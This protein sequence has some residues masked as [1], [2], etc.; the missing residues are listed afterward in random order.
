MTR[1]MKIFE[2]VFRIPRRDTEIRFVTKFNKNRPLPKGR[3]V[4]ETIKLGLR[5]T[6]PSPHFGRSR[7]KFPERCHPLTCPPVP[8]LIRIGCVL[9]D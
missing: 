4:Y 1:K 2:K 6:R 9:P 8:N 3:V 5:G 7:P